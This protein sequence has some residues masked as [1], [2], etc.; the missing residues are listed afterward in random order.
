ME[1]F[2]RAYRSSAMQLNTNYRSA[3]SITDAAHR[4]ASLLEGSESGEDISVYPAN[5]L[6]RADVF[7][8]EES[9]GSA[10][11]HR[12]LDILA[13]GIDTSILAPGE[14][15]LVRPEEIAVLG[16]TAAGLTA[17]RMQLDRLNVR[18]TSGSSENDWLESTAANIILEMIGFRAA[19]NHRYA[20]KRLA[21]LAGV[22]ALDWE[23]AADVIAMSNVPEVS[24]LAPAALCSDPAEMVARILDIDLSESGWPQDVRTIKSAWDNF[25]DVTPQRERTYSNF[26]LFIARLQRGNVESPGVRLLTIHRAQGREFKVVF[27]VGCNDG[28]LPDFRAKDPDSVRAELRAFYVAITR[29]ARA[30]FISR[31]LNR[32]TRYGS[33]RTDP[34]RFLSLVA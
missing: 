4:V 13:H 7:P 10:V 8:D 14:S 26:Q 20:K 28:Q 12:I 18:T 17:T 31:A 22:S 3:R 16:R 29:A 11:A 30:L 32:K 19:P 23:D 6:I 9:E 33:R 24:A 5:G 25:A 2:A 27:L 15:S 21:K 1:E 34:S